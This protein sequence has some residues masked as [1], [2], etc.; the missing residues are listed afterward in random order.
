MFGWDFEVSAWLR[1]WRWILIKICVGTCLNFG[2][3]NSTLGS[4]VPLAMFDSSLT[5]DSLIALSLCFRSS[6]MWQSWLW[7]TSM[8]FSL[9]LTYFI[10]QLKYIPLFSRMSKNMHV[11][12]LFV[13]YF[14]APILTEELAI[15]V[16]FNKLQHNT[17]T[18]S[19]RLRF[20]FLHCLRFLNRL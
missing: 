8:L 4:V 9:L 14:A 17:A 7:F 11:T 12:L 3:Q 19:F 15:V 13:I 2:K 10:L 5:T 18:L 16:R 1:F 6:P 20:I